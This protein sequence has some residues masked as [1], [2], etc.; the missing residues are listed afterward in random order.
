MNYEPCA[1]V[2]TPLVNSYQNNT[3]DYS[4]RSK[5]RLWYHYT[6]KY[7]Y[8][9]QPVV[10]L[11]HLRALQKNKYQCLYLNVPGSTSCILLLFKSKRFSFTS[12]LNTPLRSAVSSLF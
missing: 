11:K 7:N 8:A 5:Y 6:K 12:S 1:L 3:L 4:S 9:L 2:S 10:Y